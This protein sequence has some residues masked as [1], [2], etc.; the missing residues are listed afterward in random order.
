MND[1]ADV[2]FSM[3]LASSVHDIKNSL[4]MLL[5]SLDQVVQ[6]ES[7]TNLEQRKGLGVLHSEASRINH[8]LIHLLGLYRLQN[9]QLKLQSDEV[10]VLDFL[11]EQFASLEILFA[12]SNITVTIDCD[13][14]LVGFFDQRLIAGV[15]SNILVNCEKYTQDTL[16]LKA[17]SHGKGLII[18]I[19]DDGRGY[20]QA[21]IDHL[22]NEQRGIDFDTGSTN[23]G[24]FFASEI[25]RLH[26]CDGEH[27][28]IRISNNDI[29]G[30]FTLV[31]P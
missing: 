12:A 10:Y 15:I 16:L 1:S 11:E 6:L 8:S 25:A 7:C 13:D 28:S 19:Q 5:S 29:G 24:L 4:G 21:I 3:L 18:E 9:K 26:H 27:G 14:S 2:D 31:L 22:S 20:P 30:C 17:R 23:L